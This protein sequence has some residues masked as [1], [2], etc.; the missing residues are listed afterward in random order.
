MCTRGSV[1]RLARAS[2]EVIIRVHEI[3]KYSP[4]I[5]S[6]YKTDFPMQE[7]WFMGADAH[8]G[9]GKKGGV[10]SHAKLTKSDFMV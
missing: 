3:T 8:A 9:R 6:H 2:H 7:G 4:L 5:T 10:L 1:G